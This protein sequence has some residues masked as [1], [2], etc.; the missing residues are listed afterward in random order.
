MDEHIIHIEWDGPYRLD[1]LPA[2]KNDD[3]D[4]GVYQIYGGHPVYGSNVLLYIGKADQQTFGVRIAQ[5]GWQLNRDAGSIQVY[6]GRLAGAQTPS[7]DQWSHEIDLAEKLLIYSH[8]PAANA[9][10]LNRIPDAELQHVH[11]LN[12]G[13]HRDVMAEVSGARWT[14]KYDA[15]PTYHVYR[16]QETG[17]Q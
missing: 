13:R 12:W 10:N 15:I 14:T 1:Q 2:L 7:S 11:I 3:S 8:G 6:V 4:Y 5:E 9:R 17:E 16:W